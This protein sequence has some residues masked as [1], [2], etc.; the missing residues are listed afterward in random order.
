[1]ESGLEVRHEGPVAHIVLSRP[2]LRNAFNA[3]LI[4][5]LQRAF[6]ALA[7]DGSVRAIVLSG[8][9]K[10]F[11]GGADINWMRSSL[12]LSEDDNVEDARRLSRLLRT[13]NAVPKPVIGRVHGAALGGGA[14]LAAVCD[15]VVA[16]TQTQFGFTETKLGILPAVISPF[17][18]AKIGL[19]HAR[20][21]C[22]TGERF[23]AGRAFDIGLVHEVVP[24][25]L[26]DD[27]VKRIAGEVLTASP[28]GVA[29]TKALL[30]EVSQT[31]FDDTL[32]MTARAIARQ[33][34]SEEGQEG[35]RAFLERRKPTWTA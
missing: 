14:G 30:A 31:R 32:E 17:V 23:D 34:V 25:E 24:E 21:L 6:D 12:D 7:A 19:S 33:R 10:V 8:A 2:E 16:A 22:L 3:E 27:A 4:G 11:C 15:V 9:G 35:L 20:A 29:A 28:S 13:V 26:L 18:M 1:M 5:A